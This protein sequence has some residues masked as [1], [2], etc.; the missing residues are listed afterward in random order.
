M[1]EK[2]TEKIDGENEQLYLTTS[3]DTMIAEGP[4]ESVDWQGLRE[5]FHDEYICWSDGTNWFYHS[6]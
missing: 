4:D 2:E 5:G 3:L 1:T 6:S